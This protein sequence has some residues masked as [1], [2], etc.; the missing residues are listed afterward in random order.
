MDAEGVEVFHG[1]NREATVVRITNT[2]ELYL[3]PALQALLYEYLGS[4]CESTLC[5]GAE[6][7]LI[8]TNTAAQAAQRISRTN[9]D[10]E[11][12]AACCSNSLFHSLTSTARRNLHV[13]LV[14]FLDK[15]VTVLRIHDRLHACAKH[16]HTVLLQNTIQIERR[17]DI[18]SGLTT[19]SQH[20]AIRTFLLDNLLNKIWS[21]RQEIDLVGN[22]FAGLN[23]CH[24]GVYKHRIDAFLTQCLQSLTARI[25][26]FASLTN[27][28]RT[29]T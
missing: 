15:K 9:H 10:G 17:T 19:P 13:D 6:S 21:D 23:S 28:Q 11:T 14:Q 7:L 16:T 4:K 3:L 22:T 18:E 29:A 8:L 5:N 25:V 27:L 26:K 12:N 2:F 20:D 1:S 24:I